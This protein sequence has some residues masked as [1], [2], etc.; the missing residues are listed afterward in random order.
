MNIKAVVF[1]M[2]GVIFDSEAKVL[3]SWLVVAEKHGIQDIEKL[4]RRCLGT[5]YAETRRLALEFYGEDFPY[6]DC[7][8]RRRA[9]SYADHGPAPETGRCAGY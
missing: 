6:D 4:F 7:Q 5:T 3:E 8:P 2:D 1:D 9:Y